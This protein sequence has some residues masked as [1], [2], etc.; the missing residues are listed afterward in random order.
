MEL[1]YM[2]RAKGFRLWTTSLG[3][4]LSSMVAAC[5]TKLVVIYEQGQS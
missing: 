1:A 4:P 5:E 3:T 2:R